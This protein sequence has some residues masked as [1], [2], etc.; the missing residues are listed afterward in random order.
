VSS[1]TS[2]P[3]GRYGAVPPRRRPAVVA[4]VV[5]LATVFVGWVVWAALAASAPDATGQV[6]GFR[7]RGP[8]ALEAHLVLGGDRGPVTCTV[9]ALDATHDV[10]G[11]TTA[12]VRVGASGRVETTVVVRTRARAVAALVNGCSTGAK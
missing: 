6:T 11:V 7:V 8:H 9:Q 4:A 12:R 3:P 5:V 10:V 1:Q 2:P